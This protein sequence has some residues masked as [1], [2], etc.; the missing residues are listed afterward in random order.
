MGREWRFGLLA[1]MTIHLLDFSGCDDVFVSK[2]TPTGAVFPEGPCW[3]RD[4]A[5]LDDGR[6]LTRIESFLRR[7]GAWHPSNH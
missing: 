1:K 4:I 6:S 3:L 2:L 5:A 7:F